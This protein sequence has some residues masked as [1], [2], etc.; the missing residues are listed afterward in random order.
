MGWGV[1]QAGGRHHVIEHTAGGGRGSEGLIGSDE[2]GGDHRAP[3]MATGQVA[4]STRETPVETRHP[5]TQVPSL[6]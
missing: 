1:P 3:G 2:L 6:T 5:G 4:G